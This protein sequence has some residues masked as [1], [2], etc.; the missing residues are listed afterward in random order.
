MLNDSNLLNDPFLSH[1]NWRYH[2]GADR[3]A[4]L[5][6]SPTIET[7]VGWSLSSGL[8]GSGTLNLSPRV[9]LLRT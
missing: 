5:P 6:F 7:V 2:S 3:T 9:S 1:F 8:G 4:L